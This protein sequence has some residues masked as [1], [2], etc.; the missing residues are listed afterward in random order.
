MRE[1]C[2]GAFRATATRDTGNTVER[3]GGEEILATVLHDAY[4][5]EVSL[6]SIPGT[7]AYAITRAAK[8]RWSS[9]YHERIFGSWSVHSPDGVTRIDYDGKDFYLMVQKGSRITPAVLWQGRI[10]AAEPLGMGYF[11]AIQQLT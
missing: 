8:P 1:R 6:G 9:E 2:A 7:A 11:Q 10:S 4:E 3:S 5:L